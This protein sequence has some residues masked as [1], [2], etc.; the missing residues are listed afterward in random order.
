MSSPT[1]GETLPR[2]VGFIG[3]GAMG[4][5]MATNLAKA[6][7]PGSRVYAFDVVD[8]PVDELCSTFPHMVAKC[9]SAREAAEQ[10]VG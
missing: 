8:A 6:L 5:P 4:K 2:S 7:P 9:G 1:Q 10:S 3:L